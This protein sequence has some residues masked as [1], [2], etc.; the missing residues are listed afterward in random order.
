MFCINHPRA[1]CDSYGHYSYHCPKLPKLRMTPMEACQHFAML[2]DIPI[3]YVLPPSNMCEGMEFFYDISSMLGPLYFKS[4]SFPSSIYIS[5]T[6]FTSTTSTTYVVVSST[7]S[8]ESLSI[9]V[10]Y[11]FHM[12]NTF[13]VPSSIIGFSSTSLIVVFDTFDSNNIFFH[14]T[15]EIMEA[16]NT[17]GCSLDDM[18]HHAYFIP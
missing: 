9:D 13:K 6:M 7:T 11:V 14:S 17:P 4:P 18:H 8:I 3:E 5:L 10:S 12:S 16:L 15:E 2:Q 1:L